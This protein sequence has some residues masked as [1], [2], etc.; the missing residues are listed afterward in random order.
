[1]ESKWGPNEITVPAIDID[2]QSYLHLNLQ[3]K[4]LNDTWKLASFSKNW[5]ALK[6]SC[7][8]GAELLENHRL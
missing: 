7:K 8:G 4:N 3:I 2:I 6:R 1:M 5:S